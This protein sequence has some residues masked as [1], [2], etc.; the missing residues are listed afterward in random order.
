MFGFKKYRSLNSI[1]LHSTL[2]LT[3]IIA[4]NALAQMPLRQTTVP[5]EQVTVSK[6]TVVGN[7][8]VTNEA[9]L[10]LMSIKPGSILT[11]SSVTNDIKSIFASSYFQDVKFDKGPDGELIVSLVEKPT[12]NDIIYDGFDIV[13]TSSIKEK[14]I[15][16]KYTIVD[17]KNFHKI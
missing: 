3:A 11:S 1:T 7:K 14:I 15:T 17:E 9:V 16:K 4:G 13:S 5:W 12:V 6:I 2:S 8:T 10:N